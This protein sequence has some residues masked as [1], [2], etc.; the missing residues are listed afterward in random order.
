[1]IAAKLTVLI[2]GIA[3]HKMSAYS[4]ERLAKEIITDIRDMPD[5]L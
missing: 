3:D 1:M 5:G 2:E 4:Q